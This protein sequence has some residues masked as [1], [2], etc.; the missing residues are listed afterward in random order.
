[1]GP[2]PGYVAYGSAPTPTKRVGRIQGL[3]TAIS[4]VVAIAGLGG[5]LNGFLQMSLRSDAED[6]IAGRTSESEFNDT[7]L[8]SSAFSAVAGIATLAG[9]VL[10]MIWMYRVAANLRAYGHQTTWHPL[11]AVFGWVLPPGIL[12]V[13][14]LLMLR[15]LW[16]KSAAAPGGGVST[17]GGSNENPVLWVW[18]LFFG[19]LPLILLGFSAS[20]ALGGITDTDAE[21]VA[22]RLV[23][24]SDAI[25]LLGAGGGLIAAAAWIIFVRQLTARH[26]GLTGE[27]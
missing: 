16:S 23:D 10:V 17:D 20:S 7:V 21:D 15:E 22:E 14:P 27:N 2:P 25:T 8:S 1:M 13:I 12:Y 3:A 18:W 6:F 5:L 26:R 11:F 9:M 19:L 24:S 4:I